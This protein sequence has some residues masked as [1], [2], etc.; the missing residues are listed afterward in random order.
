MYIYI[1][2]YVS[3]CVYMYKY[4]DYPQIYRIC[5]LYMDY[6]PLSLRFSLLLE[7]SSST[8]HDLA[9]RRCP[10]SYV[11]WF[12]GPIVRIDISDITP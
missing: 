7:G 2:I 5:G 11:S 4:A 9:N 6:K 10:H 1:Y 8:S 3:T 12:I